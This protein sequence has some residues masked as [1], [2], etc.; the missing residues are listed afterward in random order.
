MHP[1]VLPKLDQLI[2]LKLSFIGLANFWT[3]RLGKS[4][5]S[6]HS[7]R[8]IERKREKEGKKG[9]E[10]QPISKKC[11]KLK[12]KLTG[13]MNLALEYFDFKNKFYCN[14]T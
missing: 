4:F 9:S 11:F 5:I 1:S 10:I 13:M 8:F 2:F 7:Q 12:E 3:S 14:P 6:N